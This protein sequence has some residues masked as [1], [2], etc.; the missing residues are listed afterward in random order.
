MAGIFSFFKKRKIV[1]EERGLLL[2]FLFEIRHSPNLRPQI[3]ELIPIL[4]FCDSRFKSVFRPRQFLSLE[5]IAR[6][7]LEKYCYFDNISSMGP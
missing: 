4:V 1:K 5:K 2:K 7:M 6:L 3:L